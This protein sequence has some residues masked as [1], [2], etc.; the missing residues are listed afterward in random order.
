MVTIQTREGSPRVPQHKV[1]QSLLLN[2]KGELWEETEVQRR[3][4]S[5][6]DKRSRKEHALHPVGSAL[7][8]RQKEML[9]STLCVQELMGQSKH[10]SGALSQLLEK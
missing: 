2:Q 3:R 8:V 6:L 1:P 4:E 7:D 5:L 10:R 9:D